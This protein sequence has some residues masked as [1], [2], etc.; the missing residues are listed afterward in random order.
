MT[1][2][3]PPGVDR[4]Y[5]VEDVSFQMNHHEVLCIVGESGSGKSMTAQAIMG[6]LPE[7]HVRVVGGQVQFRGYDLYSH[8]KAA[9]R[10][11]RG[12][13]IAMIFQEPMSALNPVLR[14][15]G[16]IEEVL[17]AHTNMRRAERKQRIIEL[18]AAVGLPDPPRLCSTYPFRLSGGQRQRV[19]I[20]MALA[21]DPDLLIAD[22]PTTALDV[23]TQK[24]ILELIASIQ[25]EHR[26]GVLFITHDFGVVAEIA[27]RVGVMQ[28]GRIV[29]IGAKEQILNSPQHPYTQ[30]LT[31]AVPT[32]QA[33]FTGYSEQSPGPIV[34][35]G[36]TKNL[37]P[38]EPVPVP[39]PRRQ[40]GKGRGFDY[41]RWTDGRPGRRV[42]VREVHLRAMP[43]TLGRC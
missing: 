22:E 27:H 26:M 41:S 15:G 1:I 5:A 31:A 8:D 30:K 21:L 4:Q 10:R 18:L 19:M 43:R 35:R 34:G 14:V 6:L 33:R 36:C 3:L 13:R 32:L 2:E 24:Q 28:D 11:L 7:P 25:A 12:N 17:R 16:Q 29:E 9:W 38:T 23:T 42:R 39:R 37:R 40:C 20:A